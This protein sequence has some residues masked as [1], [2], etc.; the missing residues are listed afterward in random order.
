[1]AVRI[2]VLG[3]ATVER[4]GVAA[5]VGGGRLSAALGLLAVR[6]GA[7][8]GAGDLVE[9]VWGDTPP[10]NE[11]SALQALLSRLRRLLPDGTLVRRGDAYLL[12]VAPADVDAAAFADAVERGAAANRTGEPQRASRIVG[13]ALRRWTGPL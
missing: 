9:A 13:E 3:E 7:A 4:D 5:A 12:D 11:A 1:M 2:R 8:V 6:P 10:A